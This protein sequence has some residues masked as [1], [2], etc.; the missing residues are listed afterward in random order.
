MRFWW[1]LLALLVLDSGPVLAGE[2]VKLSAVDPLERPAPRLDG[3]LVL[4]TSPVAPGD[5]LVP[6]LRERLAG[7][8]GDEP[9]RVI[10]TLFEPRFEARAVPP[11][12]ADRLLARRIAA[13][14]HRF[15]R[16]AAAV[17]FA[18]ERGLSRLPVVIGSVAPADVHRLAALP[19][20]RAIE[21][22][23]AL[24]AARLEGG[25]LVR[26]SEL[27][28]RLGGTGAGVG[29]AVLDTG[30]DA[31]HPELRG[32]V[33]V[34]A[35]FTGTT[36]SGAVDDSGHGTAVAG[37]LAGASGG[38]APEATIWAIKVL[39]AEGEGDSAQTLAALDALYA[40]RH[41]F[42]G[43]RVLNL[44]FV[45]SAFKTHD[46]CDL[47]PFPPGDHFPAESL[48]LSKLL[49]AG[50]TIF[51]SSGN[52]G[53]AAVSFPACLSST[54][55]VGAIYDADL[56][57]MSFPGLCGDPTTRAD[58]VPC[59]SN[60]GRALDLLAPS[61]C[62]RSPAPGGGY[63]ECFGGTSAAAPYAAGV[64]AQLLGLLPGTAPAELAAALV[65]TGTPVAD[66]HGITRN[67]VDA[68]AAYQLLAGGGPLPPPGP[69]LLSSELPGFEA[70]VLIGDATP[71]AL[72][73]DCIAQTLCASGALA[74]RPE[75][76]LKVI[77]P[78]PNG[79]L[80]AQISRFTPSR[81]EIWL[82]R[83][84][85]GQVNHYLLEAV[86]PASEDI[87]GRQDR[88]AFVP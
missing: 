44:S 55:A 7:A 86:P 72:E 14:E 71:G 63:Q 58:Q 65:A 48:A 53:V 76:F 88:E 42:G 52:D 17:G 8:A 25:G 38:M 2:P 33:G 4:E 78:R 18:P 70:K 60:S 39:D 82:R 34:E 61:F 64:A 51:A 19:E 29:A 31:E 62:A 22:V 54:L 21:P 5:K 79:F 43:L 87:P 80:W 81:V 40:A 41:D 9:V 74:G 37:I 23:I 15:V 47:A 30:V 46:S 1:P 35:D 45:S 32:R 68:L 3:E 56:G 67:R 26:S 75:L 24:R 10:V 50:V 85:T 49:A 20:V 11:E 83:L 57:P 77:G 59:F 69:W 73:P 84:S 16:A 28:A 27:R 13:L 66:A 12:E 36:G 6:L